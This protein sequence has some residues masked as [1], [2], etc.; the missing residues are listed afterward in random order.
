MRAGESSPLVHVGV[1][2]AGGD[3]SV[4]DVDM[5]SLATG[6]LRRSTEA[7]AAYVTPTFT[8]VHRD[9]GARV[10]HP[11]DVACRFGERVGETIAG[12]ALAVLSSVSRC[13]GA[14][15]AR[16]DELRTR[17]GASVP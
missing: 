2:S 9:L 11:G 7:V 13:R 15:T 1:A 14:A 5:P 17:C 6:A 3:A 16:A 10:R 8:D 12:V 4:L